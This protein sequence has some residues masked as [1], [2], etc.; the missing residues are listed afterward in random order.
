MLRI[1]A[2][3]YRGGEDEE[4]ELGTRVVVGGVEDVAGGG[5]VGGYEVGGW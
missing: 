2:R 3:G 4:F 5:Y 1:D